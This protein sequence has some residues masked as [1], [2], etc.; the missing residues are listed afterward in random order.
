MLEKILSIGPLRIVHSLVLLA[1]AAT[2]P[3]AGAAPVYAGLS[4]WPTLIAPA[5]API[6]MFVLGLDMMMAGIYRS[7]AEGAERQRFGWILKVDLLLL[8]LL[9]F[10]WL[11]FFSSLLDA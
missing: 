1:L 11:P 10:A 5:L 3:F 7:S 2:A 4:M 8:L 9:V 6:F